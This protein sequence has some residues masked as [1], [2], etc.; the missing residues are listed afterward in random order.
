MIVKIDEIEKIALLLLSKLKESKGNEIE[1]KN[2]YYW[3]IVED[4]LYN[5]CEEPKIAMLG[6]LPFD[7][8]LLLKLLHEPDDALPF[9]FKKLAA[10]LIAL[11]VEHSIAF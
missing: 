6:E 1:L 5:P 11:S 3:D 9:H 10:I 8:E 2:D 4:E 7:I